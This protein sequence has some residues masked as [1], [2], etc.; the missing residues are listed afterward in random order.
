VAI[1][2]RGIRAKFGYWSESKVKK[3]KNPGVFWQP[4][5]G[6]PW[7]GKMTKVLGG[8]LDRKWWMRLITLCSFALQFFW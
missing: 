6:N 5:V 7:L 1:I 2:T 8:Y 4:Q 3:F